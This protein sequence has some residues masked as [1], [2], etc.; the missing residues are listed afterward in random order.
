M[1]WSARRSAFLLPGLLAVAGLASPP[2]A[3]QSTERVSL[4]SAGL[5]A[6]AGS[7][8]PSISADGRYVAFQSYAV[9]LVIG[10]TNSV[11]DIFVRDRVTGLTTR[12]SLDSSGAQA[13][14]DSL[15]PFITPDGRYVAFESLASNLVP[16]DTNDV[17]DVFVHDR[18]SGQTS[19]ASISS[20]GVEGNGLSAKPSLSADGHL[21]VFSSAA[22]NLVPHDTNRGTDAFLHDLLT[23]QTRRVSVSS[24]GM[25]GYYYSENPVISSDG[26]FVAFTSY[27]S[28]LV[29]GDN[30]NSNDVFLHD[31]LTG[32]TSRV[33]VSSTGA[34][35]QLW[36]ANPVITPDGRYIAF[37]SEAN[38]LVA[39]DLN[40]VTDCFVHDHMTGTTIRVS[41]DSNGA[42]GNGKSLRPSLSMDGVLVAFH[43]LADQLVPGDTNGEQDVFVHDRQSGLTARVSVSTAGMQ[44]SGTSSAPALSADG[45]L[46]AFE[47]LARELVPGDTNGKK[48]VFVHDR[49]GAGLLLEVSGSC[50]GAI[51]LTVSHASANGQIALACGAAGA[52]VRRS[53]PCAGLILGVMPPAEIRILRADARGTAHLTL[54]APA[55]ACGRSVQAVDVV[56]CTA[57]NVIVL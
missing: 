46:I 11:A 30:N 26:R 33:S 52:F 5:Q 16:G 54:R 56:T 23:G 15:N 31:L 21:V 20:G 45:R 32:Q 55:A 2:L 27:S 28:N 18:Q 42:E 7:G 49:F 50:P 57:T 3:A 25:Q 36:S 4:D 37:E 9:D 13:N 53:P 1:A 44:G 39:G 19:R 35:A 22:D 34:E 14:D 12:I 8:A 41:V 38:N 6:S 48:D 43:S 51:T 29:N 17:Q 24:S 47:S 40:A 10:D